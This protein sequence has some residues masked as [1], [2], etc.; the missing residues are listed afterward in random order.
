MGYAA[1]WYFSSILPDRC[2]PR[3]ENLGQ[4]V[5]PALDSLEDR[6]VVAFGDFE[7]PY[8]EQLLLFDDELD[9][10]G[11]AEEAG[12]CKAEAVDGEPATEDT[13]Q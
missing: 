6:E 2:P 7:T 13:Q 10:A 11:C 8:R 9:R 12:R 3:L 1:P 4:Q 5:G